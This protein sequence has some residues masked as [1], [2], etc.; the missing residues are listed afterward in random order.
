MFDFSKKCMESFEWEI[1][2]FVFRNRTHLIQTSDCCL[3]RQQSLVWIKCVVFRT[4]KHK[5]I[6]GYILWP[7][8]GLLTHW[9]HIQVSWI[10]VQTLPRPEL[11]RPALRGNSHIWFTVGC[12]GSLTGIKVIY[13]YR[14]FS[15]MKQEYCHGD[16]FAN[17]D[18]CLHYKLWYSHWWWS[19]HSV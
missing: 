4:S 9:K 17:R 5:Y 16:S 19:H 2:E 3:Y 14:L 6:C 13:L 1:K 10:M 11:D 15:Q 8:V 18:C 12:W 7:W